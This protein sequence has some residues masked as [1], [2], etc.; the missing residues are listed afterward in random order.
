VSDI[1]INFL[2]KKNPFK[3]LVSLII[4]PFSCSL[5]TVHWPLKVTA[6]LGTTEYKSWQVYSLPIRGNNAIAQVNDHKVL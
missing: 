5:L 3:K 2:L 6:R 4:P 1:F